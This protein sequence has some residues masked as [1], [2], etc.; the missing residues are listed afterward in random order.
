MLNKLNETVLKF[1]LK[2]KLELEKAIDELK[3]HPQRFGDDL[4]RATERLQ[5]VNTA[6]GV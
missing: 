2:R 4:L 6:L 5:F 3:D 1:Y